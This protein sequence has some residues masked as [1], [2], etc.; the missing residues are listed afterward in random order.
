MAHKDAPRC[1]RRACRP[2]PHLPR[3]R[4]A[5]RQRG[6]RPG[7]GSGAGGRLPRARWC[8]SSTSTPTPTTIAASSPWPAS[9]WPCRTRSCPW[10]GSPSTGSTCGATTACTRASERWTSSRSWR[11]RT[12]TSRWPPRSPPASASGSRR[13]ST[14]R[15]SATARSRPTRIA[16]RRETSGAAVSRSSSAR[17]RRGPW[18]PTAGPTGC[19]PTAG[20]VLVGVRPPL[21]ALNVW[22]P[23]GTPH[24]GPDHRGARARDRR[25]PAR[26][27]GARPLPA[28]GGHGPGV[29]EPRGLSRHAPGA[30]H[31]RRARRGRAPGRACRPGRAGGPRAERR[32]A[33]PTPSAMGIEGFRPG[34]VLDLLVP[35]L[36]RLQAA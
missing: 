24:R 3:V 35:G 21:I 4:R 28:G 16:P 14:C 34:Q 26:R 33:G 15:S 11:S 32:P 25:R 9:P 1:S 31:R 18:S 36:A 20:A 30:G 6:T 19:H 13:S 12:R 2:R 5:E 29:D 10:R 23:D 27:A 8:A 17:S 22:L 7:H